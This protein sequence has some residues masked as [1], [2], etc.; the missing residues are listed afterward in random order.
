MNNDTDR[1]KERLQET[2][3]KLKSCHSELKVDSCLNC[4]KIFDC[5]IRKEYID[6]VYKSMSKGQTGGFEF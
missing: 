6:A 3:Q 5:E 2:T 1:Y 4:E